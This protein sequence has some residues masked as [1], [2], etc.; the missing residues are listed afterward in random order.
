MSTIKNLMG[1]FL[2]VAGIF[3]SV[4]SSSKDIDRLDNITGGGND[5][6]EEKMS[7]LPEIRM[8]A[9][10]LSKE[11]AENEVLLSSKLKDKR[12]VVSGKISRIT[13]SIMGDYPVVTLRGNSRYAGVD[14]S[15]RGKW[16]SSVGQMSK[17]D[18]VTFSCV[19][20]SASM[21]VQL[22]NCSPE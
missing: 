6:T 3:L 8:T 7:S 14:C 11:A 20:D 1:C 17:G 2:L 21:N 19:F 15:F 18:L 10:Q 13:T 12:V 5:N 16:A 4:A 22:N 9:K